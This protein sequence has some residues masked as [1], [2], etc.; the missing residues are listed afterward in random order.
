MAYGKDKKGLYSFTDKQAA[1]RDAIR[2]MEPVH[3]HWQMLESLYRT[4]AQREITQLDLNRILPFPIPGAFL[5]TVNMLLPHLT[6]VINS[7]AARDPKFVITPVGGD[8]AV[9]EQNSA[10]ARAVLDYFWKRSDATS[11]LRDM[12]QDMIITG[13]AFCK[14]GWSYSADT[15]DRTDEEIAVD[16]QEVL[17]AAAEIGV[18]EGELNEDYV[19]EMLEAVAVTE[20]RVEVDEPYVEYVSP[21]DVYVPADA[22]RMNTLRWVAQRIRLP[23][24]EVENNEL[25]DAKARKELTVDSGY[26]D[27]ATINQY[28]MQ[29]QGLPSAFAYVTIYEFYD[30]RNRTMCI[31]QLDSDRPLYEGDIPYAHRYP[32]IVH[33]R[34]FSDGGS[35]FWGFGDV[36]NVAGIQLML[37]EIMVAEIN[38]LKR[39]GNKYFI[40]KKVLTPE[41][42][43]ALQEAKADQ[44]IPVDL[45]ANIPM[46]DV[47]QPVQ[48]LATPSDNYVMEDKMQGYVQ[49]ILGISDLQAGSISSASRV[50][51][52]AVQSQMGA[53]TTR[54]ME[55]TVNVERASREIAT[56]MLALCQQFLDDNRAV[57]I[58]GPNAPTWFNVTPEDIDGE[59]S[60][61]AEG[62]ST[63][64]INPAQRA[65]QGLDILNNIVPA[66]ANFGYDPQNAMRMAIS[67]LGL[68]PDHLLV[69]PEP[70]PQP[71]QA[72]MPPEMAQGQPPAPT[73]SMVEL[74]GG[75]PSAE[76]TPEELAA[77]LPPDVAAQILG[78]MDGDTGSP[79]ELASLVPPDVAEQILAPM[80]GGGMGPSGDISDLTEDE[81]EALLAEEGL[82]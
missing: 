79:E 2:R 22:R 71:E 60:I 33:M 4:G 53:Q 11:V 35:T 5:R 29:E 80:E 75:V 39:V 50:P 14:V 16:A 31:F 13:N 62:G 68:N 26:A 6:L 69:R 63:Q 30:M 3:Q 61:E 8:P 19:N 81:L 32:P 72:G 44:I 74:G 51:A 34:N 66:L 15:R 67:Y 55:K 56:R 47:L 54:A 78:P 42:S 40:N 7:I 12:T 43:K 17:E 73:A 27:I 24:D 25:F 28:E 70:Q 46:S 76:P 49:Q 48:R 58:A 18:E 41:L 9:V 1:L 36:E 37:N 52:A 57:R 45:P 65:Q 10:I 21:Y 59:F 38:D 23:K 82:L 20:Q 64:S 77:L